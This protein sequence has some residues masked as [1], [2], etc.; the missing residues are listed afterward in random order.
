MLALIE[1]LALWADSKCEDD[2]ANVAAIL[3]LQSWDLS[4]ERSTRLVRERVK[5]Y[6]RDP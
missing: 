6:D 3:L 5:L 4:N 2:Q 1:G